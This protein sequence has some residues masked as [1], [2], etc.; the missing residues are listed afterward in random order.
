MPCGEVVDELDGLAGVGGAVGCDPRDSADA[1]FAVHVRRAAGV[2]APAEVVRPDGDGDVVDPGE[3]EQRQRVGGAAGG[4]RVAG[5]RRDADDLDRGLGEK[6]REGEGVVD[7]G[8]A[9]DEDRA[10]A[11]A[12]TPYASRRSSAGCD[13]SS[14]TA[15]APTAHARASATS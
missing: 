10:A 15:A 4:I 7:A 8:V 2:V 9:V 13:A 12:D 1:V 6:V 11:H 14:A 3:I 5:D